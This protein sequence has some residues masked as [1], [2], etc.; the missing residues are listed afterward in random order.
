[1]IIIIY[2]KENPPICIAINIRAH[3]KPRVVIE[4]IL[5]YALVCL[6]N[7]MC[8]PL[9]KMSVC[10]VKTTVLHQSYFITLILNTNYYC[11]M[12]AGINTIVMLN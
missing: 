4:S 7:A 6:A 9:L 5:K 1:M 3:S 11:V 8:A 10:V 2:K 12:N